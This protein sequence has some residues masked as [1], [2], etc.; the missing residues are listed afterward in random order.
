MP[1]FQ[2]LFRPF[3]NEVRRLISATSTTEETYYPAIKGLLTRALE[4]L[5][6][7]FEARTSTAEARAQRGV[8]L[9]DFALYD[10]AGEFLVVC[11]EVKL[12]A[13]DLRELAFSE[14]R[15]NQIGR[16]L[17][18]TGAVLV[19]N[20]RGFGLVTVKPG[21]SR[22]SPIRATDRN[23]EQ[24]VEF[25]PSANA[26]LD[27]RDVPSDAI[28]A[29]LD[30]I[31][32]AATRYAAI[33][34]PESLAK[35]LARQARQAKRELPT[36]FSQ[37]VAG[38]GEDF[39]KALGVS[40][41]GPEG[42]EFFRSSLVQT[43]FYGLFAGWTIWVRSDR[44]RPFQWEDLGD[45]LRVPFLG[46]L[47]YEFRH[48]RRI[49]ELGLKKHLDVATET[50]SRVDIGAFF[51]R[52][53][54][55]LLDAEPD[56]SA[57]IIYFYE[58]FLEAFD[59]ELRKEL[60]VWYTPVEVVRYQVRKVDRLL[61]DELGCDRGF[62]DDRVVAL[63]PCCGT[64]AYLL[65]IVRC[66]A[67]QLRAEGV[68][69]LLG[70]SLLE[71][72]R[73][74]VIGFE[75]LTAP[76]VISHL[77]L[78]LL[79][80]ELGIEPDAE[81]RLA[82]FL[83]NA[84]TGWDGPEQLRLHFPELQAEHDA[85]QGI[86]RSPRI[87]VVIGNPPYNRFVGVPMA[88]EAALVDH[89]KGIIRDDRGRQIGPTRLF[90]KWGIRKQLLNDLYIRF[91]RLAERCIGER[92]E[93]GV[94]SFISNYSFYTHRSHP[95]MRESLL[96]SF[97]CIWL[98]VLNGDKYKTGKV[99]PS[100]IPG[101]G[102]SDQSVFTTSHDPR[103]IQ[104]GTGITTLLKAKPDARGGITADVMYRNFWGKSDAKR[105]ALL[106][107][108]EMDVWNTE[109]LAEGQLRPS[110]PRPYE[111]FT[112]SAEKRWKLVPFEAEAGFGAWP[113]VDE[114]FAI[115]IQGV[116][117]NRGLK[118]SVVEID[119][120]ALETRMREY[121][122]NATDATISA[123]HPTLVTARARYDPLAVR[124]RL[125]A[126]EAFQVEKLVPYVVFPLDR[127]WL[128]YEVA[129]KLLNEARAELWRNLIDNQFFV[130]VPEPRQYSE[131]RPLLLTCAYD[132]HVHDRGSVGFP[133][134]LG[135]EAAAE[136]SLFGN[137]PE[138]H[139]RVANLHEYVWQSLKAHW[140]LAGTLADSPAKQLA[141]DLAAVGMAICHSPRYEHEHKEALAQDWAHIPIPRDRHLF[142][143]LA[144]AGRQAANLLDP[145]KSASALCRTLVGEPLARLA[146]V[147]NVNGSPVRPADLM[148]T[149]SFFGAAA[150]GW[151][152]RPAD[153]GE[154]A[155][156]AWGIGTGDLFIND[157]ISLRNVP[158]RVWS[159]EIGGYPIVKKWL[160]YRDQGRR[161]A[162]P[163]SIE[164]VNYL[165]EI[166]HRIAALL[167]L[168]SR[169]DELYE[170]AATNSFTVDEMKQVAEA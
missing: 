146:V 66:I 31:E 65:E 84:L 39:G 62:A 131:I 167:I 49:H 89:Y 81:H 8:D 52:F 153:D 121:F 163:L 104:V 119:R 11:G 64:G 109:Q 132:L 106:Q 20:V 144:A 148:V 19:S 154:L 24:T 122:S 23:L 3:A 115:G 78:Y 63:D 164:E 98:D 72:L 124:T 140:S 92:A 18:Q 151:R 134:E 96:R 137:A 150:G 61:R 88:E 29:F 56:T 147:D 101:E 71:T 40:F 114:L 43:I 129:A 22:E 160:G 123:N 130:C 103:G 108:L 165:R 169:L 166:I 51:S 85:A 77:Q 111:R 157:R 34:E 116:N 9:P 44:H 54:P 7:S 97:D 5:D 47:F 28:R 42:E 142:N 67:D 161:G 135:V 4:S 50:L 95:I 105:T 14:D 16:Y 110:G 75:I 17:A 158:E 46:E 30:V 138:P 35:V 133:A 27:A 159:Y 45:Y 83:T 120:S 113:A 112:P 91:F 168:H 48:P 79:L 94:V 26:I 53:R 100:G 86:K 41:E 55:P 107:S 149:Y 6:L 70:S 152:S 69:A 155:S 25:W 15:N 2:E 38:L 57:A 93:Y 117:P 143:D 82:V 125:R 102:T 141:R 139:S 162:V 36:Q 21:T 68:G 127:R 80:S 136:G 156:E 126:T 58:P 118:G 99:I 59:P 60:G 12:P 90:S 87:I 73:K 145:L 74:R 13:A 1:E 170:A 33:A 37:A 128:Y 10:G 32:T 76:F